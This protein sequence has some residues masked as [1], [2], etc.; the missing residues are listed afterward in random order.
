MSEKR[1]ARIQELKAKIDNW[2][3]ELE[4]L[5]AEADHAGGEAKA[6]YHRQMEELRAKSREIKDRIEVLEDESGSAFEDIKQ[7]VEASWQ[8]WKESFSKASSEFKKGYK[9]SREK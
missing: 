8:T 1:D 7:G 5:T 3:A 2:N 4:K 6:G 9:D